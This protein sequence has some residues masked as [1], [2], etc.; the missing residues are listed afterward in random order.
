MPDELQLMSS[1]LSVTLSEPVSYRYQLGN[2][3]NVILLYKV[4]INSNLGGTAGI[5]RPC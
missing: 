3:T 1:K 5:A 2:V 4:A